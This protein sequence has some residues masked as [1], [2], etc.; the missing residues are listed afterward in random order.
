MK[1]VGGV[2]SCSL[3]PGLLPEG[4]LLQD[5]GG[6]SLEGCE[7]PDSRLPRWRDPG[8]SRHISHI[9]ALPVS[10]FPFMPK[11]EIFPVSISQSL[12]DVPELLNLSSFSPPLY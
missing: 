1:G 12:V 6:L 8:T 9:S 4:L 7:N 2:G 10:C 11:L 5:F 3:L